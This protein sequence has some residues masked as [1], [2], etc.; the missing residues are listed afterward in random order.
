ME[1]GAPPKLPVCFVISPI[2][3]LN[4]ERR[5]RADQALQR[6]RAAARK[7]GYDAQRS[8]QTV[9]I[10]QITSEFIK[11]ILEAPLVIADLTEVNANVYYELAIRHVINKPIVLVAQEGVNPPFDVQN[12][13]IVHYNIEYPEVLGFIDKIADHIKLAVSGNVPSDNPITPVFEQM[14]VRLLFPDKATKPARL[15]RI[16][17]VLPRGR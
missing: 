14:G 9:K 3:E 8:D 15:N 4:S 17:E 6:I 13:H 10:G 16:P 1:D 11:A 12:Q 5:R 7:V 2:G